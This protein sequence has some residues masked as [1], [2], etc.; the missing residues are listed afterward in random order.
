MHPNFSQDEPYFHQNMMSHQNFDVHFQ[1]AGYFYPHRKPSEELYQ[2][3]GPYN[4]GILEMRKEK[5][6]DAARSRRGKENYEFYELAKMLPLPPQ[7]T[8]QLDKASIIRL[9]IAFLKLKEFTSNGDPPWN[10]MGSGTGKGLKIHSSLHPPGFSPDQIE[11]FQGTHILQSLDGF[12]FSLGHD[13]RFLY[14]SETVSIYLGLSQVEL[15]GSS[16]FDYIHTADHQELADQLG[17][18]LNLSNSTSSNFPPSPAS[19]S[20]NGDDLGSESTGMS[21][22]SISKDADYK[23]FDRAFCLRMKSTLTKRGCHMKSSGYRVILIVGRMRAQQT[24]ATSSD[25]TKSSKLLGL[26]ALALAL[27]PP[28]AHELKLESDM[29]VMRL[30]FE[31][32]VVHCEPRISDLMEFTSE[33]LTGKSLYSFSH[34]EDLEKL[35]R[36]HCDLINKGQAMSGCLRMLNRHGGFSWVQLCAT[37][38]CSSKNSEEQSIVCVTYVLSRPDYG[39]FPM[40][41]SQLETDIKATDI[42]VETPISET[43]APT[44]EVI[45]ICDSGVTVEMRP[46]FNQVQDLDSVEVPTEVARIGSSENEET[47]AARPDPARESE[48]VRSPSGVSRRGRKRKN[49]SEQL[50]KED[51]KHG[52]E[53]DMERWK[54]NF[55]NNAETDIRELERLDGHVD[56]STEA[57]LGK[58]RPTIQ[59]IGSPPDASTPLAVPSLLR[60]LYASRESVIRPNV[61]VQ[62]TYTS[63]TTGIDG[64]NYDPFVSP[65]TPSY[66]P[67]YLPSMTP[68]SSVSPRES[69]PTMFSDTLRSQYQ[70]SD[71]SGFGTSSQSLPL[72]HLYSGVPGLDTG[73][74]SNDASQFYSHT[75]AS[76]FHLYHPQV[77]KN[78]TYT[79]L[80]KPNQ[81]YSS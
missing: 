64:T 23:G 25:G 11:Q 58:H 75:A 53:P 55:N 35:R 16:V 22:M 78:Q 5:S 44:A 15:T 1:S 61:Q 65:Y 80:L 54:R 73:L 42:K 71:G 48:I 41:T 52:D 47:Y 51:N 57:L 8:S 77:G 59:W 36:C 17:I 66:L 33:E 74:V 40:D 37:V 29:F 70:L 72:K 38:V 28:A 31:F 76:S 69:H 13:G 20:G 14:I 2:Q 21:N 68:P 19:G 34:G 10:N 32:K 9:T 81:W 56:F 43:S 67:D 4:T 3:V 39:G 63:P 45:N 26:V 30:N 24:G 12:A 50:D 6:R 49:Q 79:D 27:P 62:H 46:Q 7:I 60:R 18:N